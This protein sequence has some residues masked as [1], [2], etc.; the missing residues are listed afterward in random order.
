MEK[1]NWV[2]AMTET[3]NDAHAISRQA[4]TWLER[5]DCENWNADDQRAL[6]AWLNEAP[7]HRL[8]YWRVRGAWAHT[9]RLPALRKRS[10]NAAEPY[11]TKRWARLGAACVAVGITY[12]AMN[13]ALFSRVFDKSYSTGVGIRESITLPDGSQIDLNTDTLLH[14]AQSQRRVTLDHGEAF[15]FIKHDTMHPFVVIA[16]AQ[17]IVDLGT[18]FSVRRYTNRT[19]VALV[20]GR[21]RIEPLREN[22]SAR[23]VVLVPGE[24]AVDDEHS[25]RLTNKSRQ[26]LA[27]ELGWRRGV[28][29]FRRTGL[30]EAVGQFNRYNTHKLVIA[31][32]AAHL[33]IGGTFQANNPSV[34]A[35]VA[36]DVLELHVEERG[37][38]T[39][40]SR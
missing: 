17:R 24:V 16:G 21:A 15:F 22:L 30:A 12:I 3:R 14:V 38:E 34:F 2:V 20:E 40:I 33:Q 7:V 26:E 36:R 29:V 25:L 19:E 39:V 31:D 11:R 35:R 23:P 18:R 28:L 32:S 4:A 9:A 5:S 1:R 37:D 10:D 13:T 8:A 27:D 6:D